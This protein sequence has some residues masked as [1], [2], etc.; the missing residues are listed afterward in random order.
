MLLKML[1]AD[2]NPAW[3]RVLALELFRNVCSNF[4][5]LH[6]IF[7]RYSNNKGKAKGI[8]HTLLNALDH[9]AAETPLVFREMIGEVEPDSL[10]AGA[11]S[12]EE[13]GAILDTRCRLKIAW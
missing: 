3:Q 9:A 11:S 12:A 1:E 7:S 4:Q 13:Q 6:S 8:Y 5:L 2:Q 10:L